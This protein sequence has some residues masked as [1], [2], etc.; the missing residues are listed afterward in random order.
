M[1]TSLDDLR[2]ED[3][4]VVVDTHTIEAFTGLGHPHDHRPAPMQI[5]THDLRAVVLC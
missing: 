4:R 1:L 5:D 2:R 3:H